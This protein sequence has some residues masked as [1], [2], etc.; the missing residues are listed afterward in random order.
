MAKKNPEIETH[1]RFYDVAHSQ[2]KIFFKEGAVLG[3]VENYLSKKVQAK[4]AEFRLKEAVA[5]R[6]L[7]IDLDKIKPEEKDEILGRELFKLKTKNK[8]ISIVSAERIE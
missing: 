4:R 2:E 8:P 6:G 1:K 3:T 7:K 5:K